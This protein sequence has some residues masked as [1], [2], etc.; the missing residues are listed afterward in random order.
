RLV[1]VLTHCL[2]EM[3][4]RL[5]VL[6]LLV[7]RDPQPHEGIRPLGVLPEGRLEL[8]RGV[9]I[10]TLVERGLSQTV[11]GRAAAERKDERGEQRRI[12]PAPRQRDAIHGRPSDSHDGSSLRRSFNAA[13]CWEKLCRPSSHW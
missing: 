9:G 10:A 6:L 7:P 1:R 13:G 3:G 12:V 11:G 2:A 4:N 8:R 5:V